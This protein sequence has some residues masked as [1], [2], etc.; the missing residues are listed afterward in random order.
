MALIPTDDA[1]NQNACADHARSHT[2]RFDLR[3]PDAAL[4]SVGEIM[5]KRQLKTH[6]C[7]A[8]FMSNMIV[9][10][11]VRVRQRILSAGPCLD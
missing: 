5:K 10:I 1:T 3:C 8:S 2:T 4:E 9:C 11:R 7:G 6:H